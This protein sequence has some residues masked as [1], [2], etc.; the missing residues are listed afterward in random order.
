[1]FTA[2]DLSY[3]RENKHLQYVNTNAAYYLINFRFAPLKSNKRMKN[4]FFT[5]ILYFIIFCSNAQELKRF[6]GT[7]GKW[8]FHDINGKEIIPAIYL[9]AFNFSEGLAP[10]LLENASKKGYKMIYIDKS[11]KEIISLKYDKAFPFSEGLAIVELNNKYGYIDKLG[12]EIIPLKY[13]RTDD[14]KNGVAVVYKKYKAGLINKTGKEIT[15][16]KYSEI[17]NFID[18]FAI[19]KIGSLREMYDENKKIKC[20]FITETGKEIALEYDNVENFHE[21]LAAVN[22]GAEVI[23]SCGFMLRGGKWGFIDTSG[24]II[25]P[26]EYD[27]V[28]PFVNGKAGVELN[29]NYFYIDKTGKKLND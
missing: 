16:F 25:I 5:T 17:E 10:V 20:G 18:G 4:V 28:R 27:S 22:I 21:G 8:G 29:G 2:K 1:M 13:D 9:N 23:L 14:F 7:N 3:W 11:G 24:K 12:K 15:S 19:V 6:I 26:I